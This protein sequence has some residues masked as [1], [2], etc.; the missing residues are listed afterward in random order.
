[1][2]ELNK[3]LGIKVAA[4]TAYH[5][6]SD[7]QTERVNQEI[8][9]YLQLFVNQCQDD[10]LEWISLAEFAYNNCIHLATQTTPFM[11]N[12]GQHPRLG[13]EPTQETQLEALDEF[14][15]HMEM[16]SKKPALTCQ[17]LQM[18]WHDCTTCIVRLLPHTRLVIRSG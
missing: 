14:T 13:L 15:T 7:G 1:M 4:S 3:L 5:P 10:W 2:Q 9:Q 6:Q 18:I 8:E 17:R 16:A 11:L 12:N